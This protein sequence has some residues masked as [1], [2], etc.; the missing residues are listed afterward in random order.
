MN[1]KFA[2]LAG[3]LRISLRVLALANCS[4]WVIV[5]RRLRKST[6]SHFGTILACDRRTDG[7]TTDGHRVIYHDSVASHDISVGCNC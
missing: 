1:K 6:F 3:L 4:I 5:L 7:H 2:S